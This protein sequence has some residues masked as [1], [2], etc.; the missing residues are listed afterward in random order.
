MRTRSEEKECTD[1]R[2]GCTENVGRMAWSTI[3]RLDPSFVFCG[4]GGW[5]HAGTGKSTDVGIGDG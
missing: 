3:E 4:V 1:E 2:F 5:L